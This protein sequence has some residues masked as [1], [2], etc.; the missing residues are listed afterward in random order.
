MVKLRDC[1]RELRRRHVFRVAAMYIVAAWVGVQVASLIF[2]A[3]DIPEAALRFVWA[4]F[5]LAF[6]PVMVFAWLYDITP[7]GITRTPP[8]DQEAKLDL[9]LRRTDYAI[10]IV[11]LAVISAMAFQLSSQIRDFESASKKL[12]DLELLDAHTIVVLPL[13]N[14]AGDDTQQFLVDGM[15]DAL[16]S[17]L[18]RV[19][20]LRIISRTSARRFVDS[21]KSLMEIGQEL[22][23]AN[24][25]EGSVVRQGNSIRIS[26]Q[27]INA[28]S[29][30]LIWANMYDRQF[31]DVLRLQSEV[32]RTI[33]GEV[34][35]LLTPEEA[36][37]LAATARVVP[38]AY[39]NY[40]K[41]RFHW[42]R[43]G[44]KDLELAQEYFKAAINLDPGYALAYVGLADALATPGHIGLLPSADVFPR[45]E[46][47]AANALELDPLLAE[48]HDFSARIRFVW[49][50]DWLGADRGFREAIRLNANHPDARIVYSQFLG[51]HR[52]WEES[53]Q[54]VLA[55]LKLDPLNNWFR[56]ELGARL[57]W[58]GKYE[59]ALEEFLQVAS[60]D[61]NWFMIY[62]YLWEIHFYRGEME[63]ALGA[64][65]K[66]YE[67]SG[68]THF[69][70]ALSDLNAGTEYSAAMHS[71]ASVMIAN[72]TT[73][74]VSD[75]EL[76]RIFAFAGDR[77]STLQWLER[78]EANRDTQLVYSAV[79][80]VF[81]LVWTEP[82]Y[83]RLRQKMNLPE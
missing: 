52:R 2:P 61:P 15:H 16:I 39:E 10:L 58:Q 49:N 21:D 78:A 30:Q 36:A 43:F 53:M 64:A 3:V 51:I 42:Y 62:R 80:P 28:A 13:E 70:E 25:I 23:A 12:A 14:V 67:L 1:L 77:A 81:S 32:A 20:A 35:V 65:K 59:D 7:D 33:A 48:A 50:F 82:R 9:R 18:S 63:K 79:Q 56:I 31:E 5:L 22:H 69:R 40:L 24:I 11:L 29:E 73:S 74:Y 34:K 37:Y 75:F 6:L 66:F 72:S 19:S 8:A 27:L 68:Q 47:L 17:M 4:G 26:V 45:A 41:G 71:L 83:T 60:D 38:E 44:E 46:A 76:A 55:G 54:Q 57:A